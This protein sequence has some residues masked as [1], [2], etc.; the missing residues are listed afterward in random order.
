[1]RLAAS[2]RRHSRHPAGA[3][4][5]VALRPAPRRTMARVLAIAAALLAYSFGP[6]AAAESKPGELKLRLGLGSTP[7]PALPNSVLWLAKDLGFYKRE[8]L[9]VE[10]I[11][12]NGTPIA[13][14]AM[15]AGEI[16]IGNIG[17]SDVIRLVATKRQSM[18]AIHSPDARL[19]FLIAARDELASA[20]A[21]EGKQFGV[22]RIGSVDHSMSTIALKALGANTAKISMIAI[23]SPSTRAQALVAGRI[24]ATTLSIGSWVTIRKEAGIKVLVDQDVYFDTATVVQKVNAATTKVIQEKPDHLRRFTAAI[25]KASRH[26]AENQDSWVEAITKRRADVERKD[27]VSLWNNFKTAWAVNGLI[28]LDSYKK[29]SEF[30]YQSGTLDKIPKIDVGEWSETRFVDDVLKEIGVY[31]KFDPLGRAIK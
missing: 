18:R 12:F 30:F 14:A 31:G 1:M 11:E 24:D 29:S 25:I 4:T 8:G 15:I 3:V 7:A 26:F 19:Y 16:D 13:I 21:L 6:A 2:V 20:R 17:T 10:L 23:G 22:A 9:E 5:N 28:N 27:A